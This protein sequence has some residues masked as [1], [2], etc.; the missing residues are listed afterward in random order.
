VVAE[1]ARC[2]KANRFKYVNNTKGSMMVLQCYDETK[3]RKVKASSGTKTLGTISN[4]GMSSPKCMGTKKV[5]QG[6]PV[7][8][9]PNAVKYKSAFNY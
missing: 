8:P 7:T 2:K 4:M 9:K 1:I 5:M 3:K 6:G